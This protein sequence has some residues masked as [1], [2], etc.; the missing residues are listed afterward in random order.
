MLRPVVSSQPIE[1]AP[2]TTM[3]RTVIEKPTDVGR[4]IVYD[5]RPRDSAPHPRLFKG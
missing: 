1:E 2:T 5:R 4:V 3:N